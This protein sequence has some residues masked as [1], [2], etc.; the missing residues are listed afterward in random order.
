MK[1]L[2]LIPLLFLLAGCAVPLRGGK[3]SFQ[4]PSGVAGTVQQPQNPK[5]ESTQVWERT[6]GTVTEKV[7]TKI[8]AAQKDVAREM[9]A[10]LAS[11]RPVMYVGILIFLFGAASMFWPPLKLIVG[12]TTTS[13]VAC[14]A[15]VALIALPTVIVGNEL[16]IMGVGVGAVVLY[17]FSHRHGKL[18]GLVDANKDGIDDRKQKL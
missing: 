4:S 17:W 5:D 11:L 3:A 12:S 15:G 7:T 2:F 8:G 9:G 13:I 16:L 1:I 6:D 14:V 18:Q 10:K